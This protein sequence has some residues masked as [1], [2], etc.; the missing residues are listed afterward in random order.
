[1]NYETFVH[2]AAMEFSDYLPKG[3]EQYHTLI[4]ADKKGM[5]ERCI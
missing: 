2:R 3:L 5:D 1:M 4:K